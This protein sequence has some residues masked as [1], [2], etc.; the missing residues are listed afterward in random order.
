MQALWLIGFCTEAFVFWG[1]FRRLDFGILRF[2]VVPL[3]VQRNFRGRILIDCRRADNQWK[4]FAFWLNV[5]WLWLCS[6]LFF[7]FALP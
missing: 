7:P 1:R 2:V 6:P 3:L 5:L 4:R